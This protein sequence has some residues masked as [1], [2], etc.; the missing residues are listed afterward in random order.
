MVFLSGIE[1]KLG[2][3]IEELEFMQKSE[4]IYLLYK[5]ES[6][7]ELAQLATMVYE[8]KREDLTNEI[9]Y[10]L[11]NYFSMNPSDI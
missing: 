4:L 6:E 1:Q 7:K 8:T 3:T 5:L 2:I 11:S 10:L 9:N